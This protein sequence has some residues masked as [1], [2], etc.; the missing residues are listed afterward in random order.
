MAGWYQNAASIYYLLY[1]ATNVLLSIQSISGTH[2]ALYSV[3]ARCIVGAVSRFFNGPQ[4]GTSP[5]FPL[6]LARE[7]PSSRWA[8]IQDG[9]THILRRVTNITEL[10]FCGPLGGRGVA[11]IAPQDRLLSLRQRRR[12]TARFIYYALAV[13]WERRLRCLRSVNQSVQAG[14]MSSEGLVGLLIMNYS[15]R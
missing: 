6:V 4:N 8:F 3:C 12:S 13:D 14:R 11:R 2:W 7:R 10:V 15:P 5:Y 1:S 9:G